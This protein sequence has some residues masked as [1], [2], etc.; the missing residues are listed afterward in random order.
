MK[1]PIVEVKEQ[2]LVVLTEFDG[3]F[4]GSIM[5]TRHNL[6]DNRIRHVIDSNG[7]L[8]SFTF[9][10]TNHTGLRR[11]FSA[12]IWNIS[13]DRYTYSKEVSISVGRFRD[14]V[15]AHRRDLDPDFREAATALF[16]SV[17]SCNSSDPLRSHIHLLNL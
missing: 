8:W 17:A 3:T 7:D 12:I 13:H 10:D 16:E 1:T 9:T 6:E 2:H 14:I 5:Q 15:D 11:L 4:D